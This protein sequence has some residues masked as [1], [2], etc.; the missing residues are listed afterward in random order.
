MSGSLRTWSPTT[1]HRIPGGRS[2]G[3]VSPVHTAGRRLVSSDRQAGERSPVVATR[4]GALLG[5]L[6]STVLAGCG[7]RDAPNSPSSRRRSYPSVEPAAF[8]LL[9]N[10]PTTFV[11]NV[12]TPDEGSIPGTDAA[13]P[14]DQLVR[15][16]REL[17]DRSRAVAVY[18]RTGRMS[19]AAV[20]TLRSLGFTRITELSGGM[21]AW[22]ADGR[23]LLP[24]SGSPS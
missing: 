2:D 8:A 21:Q 19:A 18:C 20:P 9:V 22:E 3:L 1:P 16:A 23:R 15:R 5:V 10:E 14:F 11:L 4:R 12:H 7:G 24:P 17:P 13:V 6:V